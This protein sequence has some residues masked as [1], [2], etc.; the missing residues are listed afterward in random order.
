MT[1]EGDHPAKPVD[2]QA[3]L[4]TEL[5]GQLAAAQLALETAIAE[6][7]RA[8]GDV[9][10]LS[11]SRA[12]LSALID[13][14]QQIGFANGPALA[15]LRAEAAAASQSASTLAQQASDSASN[16]AGAGNSNQAQAARRAIEEVGQ[17]LFERHTLDKYLKFTST[18]D[19]EEYRKR[20][21]QRQ[22]ERAR[23]LAQHTPEGDRLALQIER[24]QLRDAGKHGAAASPE[25]RAMEEKLA[26]A[27]K[28]LSIS[29]GRGSSPA[30]ASER[31]NA[32][33]GSA[34][35]S[36]DM[37]DIL[38]TL[39]AAGVQTTEPAKSDGHGLAAGA[40]SPAGQGT[41]IG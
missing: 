7:S 33:K 29:E 36:D 30:T 24:D 40:R 12:Q 18:E 26:R 41:Q 19:E 38:A 5:V 13:L 39:K 28:D 35:P 37:A 14:R 16:S 9:A 27:E 25:Y 4:R 10:T 1:V 11:A 8:G 34:Q 6:L 20:E 17:D 32:A 3:S 2:P 22:E 21:Q 15:N 31:E 23:A